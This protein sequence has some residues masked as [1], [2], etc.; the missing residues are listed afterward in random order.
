M[1]S[2]VSCNSMRQGKARPLADIGNV[3]HGL[4]WV[5]KAGSV[6]VDKTAAA[7]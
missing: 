5:M 1:T 7:K 2:V 4:R 3:I 6:V